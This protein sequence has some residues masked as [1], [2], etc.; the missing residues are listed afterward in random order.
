MG[1]RGKPLRHCEGVGCYG[2]GGKGRVAVVVGER[3]SD[4]ELK[5]VWWVFGRV[6]ES[7]TVRGWSGLWSEEGR[8]WWW[9]ALIE[10]C[11]RQKG[12]QGGWEGM[13]R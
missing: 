6:N 4:V 8:M 2:R 5:V 13:R 11:D 12:G 10:F 3:E 9:H 1:R 7:D